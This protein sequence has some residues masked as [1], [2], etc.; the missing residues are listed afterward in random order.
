M[1]EGKQSN[2]GLKIAIAVLIALLLGSGAYLF[3]M[4]DDHK[5]QQDFLK[6]EMSHLDDQLT[7]RIDLLKKKSEEY[8]MLENEFETQRAQLESLQEELKNAKDDISAL[9][10]YRSLYFKYKKENDNLFKKIDSLKIVNER[11]KTTLDSTTVA[12]VERDIVVDSLTIDNIN[13]TQTIS[14]AKELSIASL[15][16]VGIIERSS[17]KQVLTDKAR[18]VDKVKLCFAVAANKVAEKG[19]RV[20]Y[21]QILDPK[22]N[23]IGSK[24]TIDVNGMSLTYSVETKF[25]YNN[26][27]IDVCEYINEENFEKGTYFVNIFQDGVTIANT[28]FTLR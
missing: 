17:G 13:K 20:Y 27:T 25:Y 3:K 22:N 1:P 24:E 15:N 23:V 2:K 16:S 7:E 5:E 28:T 9:K 21:I 26:K 18:R 12:L 10:R 19:D 8:G 14:A 6:S 11:I 4:K